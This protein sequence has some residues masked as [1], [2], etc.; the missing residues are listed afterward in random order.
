MLKRGVRGV[1]DTK[2][3]NFLRHRHPMY[4]Q[5]CIVRQRLPTNQPGAV[6][7]M[8][9]DGGSFTWDGT[10]LRHIIN[11]PFEAD[12]A[13]WSTPVKARATNASHASQRISHVI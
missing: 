9:P 11:E 1:A 5:A 6:R 2:A 12:L 8:F 10:N 3:R 13:A 7:A 4:T